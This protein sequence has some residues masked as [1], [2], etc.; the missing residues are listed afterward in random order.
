MLNTIGKV[1]FVAWFAIVTVILMAYAA[2]TGAPIQQLSEG[3]SQVDVTSLLAMLLSLTGFGAF[4]SF[5]VD[6]LK[7]F[8]YVE[9]GTSQNWTTLLNLIGLVGLFLLNIFNP[10]LV[11]PT[12]AVL[13]ALA[14]VG[15][16]AL[17]LLFPNAISRVTHVLFR[18]VPVIGTSFSVKAA[19]AM[20]RA[21]MAPQVK[22]GEAPG[23][24]KK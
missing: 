6:A 13:A 7:Q 4:V 20:A 1:L 11:K 24:A 18:G 19:R 9:D 15:L 12:D 16:I 3:V 21:A 5:A 22:P 2:L 8:G 23:T 17:G 10:A 14:Q